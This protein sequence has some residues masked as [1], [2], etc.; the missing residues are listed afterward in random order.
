MS[1]EGEPKTDDEEPFIADGLAA[2]AYNEDGVDVTL[3]R[4]F[5]RLT[6]AERLDEASASA[7]GI[8]ELRAL[9]AS[10]SR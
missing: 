1:G 7:N 3:I 2:G 6:P 4:M 9:Q 10:A 5:L 8:E